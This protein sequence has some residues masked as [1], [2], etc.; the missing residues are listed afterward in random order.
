MNNWKSWAV[1]IVIAVVVIVAAK[2]IPTS[3]LVTDNTNSMQVSSVNAE[4][5]AKYLTSIGAKMY[6]S[7]TCHACEYQ[8]EQFADAWQFINYVECGPNGSE[9]D[10]QACDA[11]EIGAYPTWEFPGKGKVVGAM[12]LLDLAK[13]IGFGQ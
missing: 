10:L 2:F 9:E 5:L 13:E 6:G 8:K 11:A 7:E 1:L 3:S 12:T 4:D